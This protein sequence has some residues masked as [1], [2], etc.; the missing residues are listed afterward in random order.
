MQAVVYWLQNHPLAVAFALF[1]LSC[2]V[3][4]YAAEIRFFLT[5]WP[6]NKLREATLNRAKS[7]LRTLN[8][9]HENS[10]HLLLWFLW[11]IT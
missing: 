6:R 10:Y 11:N 7:R 3:S 9:L 8:M 5:K 4:L 1:V 2:V